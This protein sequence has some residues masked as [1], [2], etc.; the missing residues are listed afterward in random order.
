MRIQR[1]FRAL[2]A[3][4]RQRRRG[5]SQED[6]FTLIEIMIVVVII[7]LLAGLVAINLLPQAEQAKR[8]TARTQ[9]KTF[10]QALDLYRLD[11]GRYPTT[12]QGLEALIEGGRRGEAYLRGSIPKDPW[13]NE[14]AY[15]SPGDGG[16]PYEIISYGADGQP[17]GT[18]DNADISNWGDEGS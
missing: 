16:R 1:D 6:G 9:M 13:G 15:L 3:A 8:T 14:Y 4:A 7:G 17:G 11:N 10:E 5:G 18:G 12:E 2:Q